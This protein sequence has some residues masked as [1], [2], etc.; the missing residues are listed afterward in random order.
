MANLVLLTTESAT[1]VSDIADSVSTA[2]T[3]AGSDLM[4]MIATIAP[5]A[6]GVVVAVMVVKKGVGI[7]KS[8]SGNK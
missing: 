5:I 8:I 3:G 6:I 4:S 1:S 2:L 7:F